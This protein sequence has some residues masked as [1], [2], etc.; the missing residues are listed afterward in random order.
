MLA[1][2]AHFD[3]YSQAGEGNAQTTLLW[4]ERLY[5]FFVAEAPLQ[6]RE[7][8]RVIIFKSPAEYAAYRSHPAADAYFLSTPAREYLVLSAMGP[9]EFRIAAHEYA[10]L[11]LHSIG[12]HVRPWLAEGLAEFF[13]TVRIGEDGTFIGGDLPMRSLVLQQTSWIPLADLLS[14]S[15]PLS[16][17]RK[18]TDVFYAESW[19]LTDMLITSP[20]YR[21]HFA[22]LLSDRLP[23]ESDAEA[24]AR[25]YGRPLSAVFADLHTWLRTP[26]SSTPLPGVPNATTH[27]E[28]SELTDWESRAVLADLLLAAEWWKRAEPA[29]RQLIDEKPDDA[30]A[31]AALALIALHNGNQISAREE[32]QRAM[33]IGVRDASICYRFAVSA[34]D[35][36]LPTADIRAALERAIALAPNFDDARY[37]LAL[38]QNIAGNY[39]AA[40]TQ[41][42]AM[43]SVPPERA[44]AY[45]T[46]M[47]SALT[48]A[49]EREA[50]KNAA[51]NAMRYATTSEQRVSA[52]SLAYAAMTDLTVQFARDAQGH[53]QVVTARK[54]HGSDDW[55]PFIE[56]GDDI[57]R[58]E[59]RIR[60]VECKS[61]KISG[62]RIETASGTV[63]VILLDPTHVLIQ[64]GSPEF[65]CGAQDGRTVSIQYAASN[66]HPP[67]N[68]VLRGMQF[69]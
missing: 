10:H 69:K 31:H 34:E 28:I 47:A 49:D 27:A 8:V 16:A 12:V 45:W 57:R 29:F 56:P 36:S 61:G 52:S 67:A 41:L 19:A 22:E 42:R 44:Y 33:Q 9:Q 48:D 54:P 53:L 51:E 65:V 11:V 1:H 30:T 17:D 35:A 38:L 40:L 13:S 50:A 5:A 14:A 32:W 7:P 62:F 59:G 63:Q 55:N 58:V 39:T 25:I 37:K 26:R 46:V 23:R 64:G 4:L 60:K 6:Q 20:K 66:S 24:I 15:S 43:R 2:S 18:Q 21:A 3:V 68:G